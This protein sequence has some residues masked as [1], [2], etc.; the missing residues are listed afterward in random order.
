MN[1]NLSE[2]NF[3][4]TTETLQDKLPQAFSNRIKIIKVLKKKHKLI[5]HF[6]ELNLRNSL[7]EAKSFITRT[8]S[9]PL[10]NIVKWQIE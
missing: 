3:L 7:N 9:L 4:S 10:F 2:S 1:N 5:I 6:P 8:K